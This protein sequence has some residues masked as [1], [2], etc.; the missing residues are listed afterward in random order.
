MVDT[1]VIT[2]GNVPNTENFVLQQIALVVD[3]FDSG[4]IHETKG[5]FLTVEC[6]K[7]REKI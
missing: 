3:R 7:L 1:V 2:R 6:V 5:L 4:Y